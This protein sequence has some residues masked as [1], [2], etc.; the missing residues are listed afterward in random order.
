MSA[1]FVYNKLM[2]QNPLTQ[3]ISEF[4]IAIGLEVFPLKID[5]ETFLNG[6][7]IKNGQLFVDES[8]LEFPGDL[9]HEAGHL[10]VAPANLRSQLSD[11]VE[12]PDLNIDSLESAAML[13]S[14]A[15]AIHLQIDPRIVFH[16]GGYKGNSE[17]ILF[18]YSLGVFF[19]L[20]LLEE[21][22]MTFNSVNAKIIG[23][24]PFPR[25]VKWLRN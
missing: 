23:I 21:A 1:F 3:K 25:M 17:S 16:E 8:N 20:N 12:L 14:Y 9:L 4:L 2:F 10:A 19:G 13:W 5:D 6:I 7:L 18:N 22:E 15:A 24:E 11:T